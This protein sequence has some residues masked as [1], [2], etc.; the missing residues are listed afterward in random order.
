M[1]DALRVVCYERRKQS[2]KGYSS[3]QQ[4]IV[5]RKSA[6]PLQL[7]FVSTGMTFVF[8]LDNLTMDSRLTLILSVPVGCRLRLCESDDGQSVGGITLNSDQA[9][10]VLFIS[11]V[12]MKYGI[13][14]RG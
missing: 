5:L 1:V 9:I 14:G 4:R 3:Q 2:T 13:R 6:L 8:V 11:R 10:A 7:I 12:Y